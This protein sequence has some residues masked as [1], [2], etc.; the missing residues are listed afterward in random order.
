MLA[1]GLVIALVGYAGFQWARPAAVVAARLT[2]D[3]LYVL[4]KRANPVFA[5]QLRIHRQT[6]SADDRLSD[7]AVPASG[8]VAV[9]DLGPGSAAEAAPPS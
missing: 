8:S 5:A 4:L 6:A 3:G 1:L 9:L 7:A 2:Q